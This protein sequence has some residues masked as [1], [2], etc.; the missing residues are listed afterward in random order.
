MEK[1]TLEKMEALGKLPL[2]VIQD[3][4]VASILA[5]DFAC[6]PIC[7][8]PLGAGAATGTGGD[9]NI[10][11]T[12]KGNYRYHMLGTQTIVGFSPNALGMKIDLDQTADDGVELVPFGITSN[13]PAAFTVGSDAA[14]YARCRLYITDVS[15]T[16]DLAFGFRK[17]EAFQANID[18]YDEMAAI[19]LISGDI[20]IETILNGGATSTTDTTDNVADLAII[21]LYVEVSNAG[22]VTFKHGLNG[23]LAAPTVTASFTFDSAEVVVPF[24]YFLHATDVASGVYISKWE[25]GYVSEQN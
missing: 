18:D 25:V 24:L 10:C 7:A 3:A 21:D 13:S 15:G 1:L 20:K 23:G 12:A 2:K 11:M 9:E 5:D 8:A 14:F 16:D 4:S 6:D 17:L 22:V 19:N